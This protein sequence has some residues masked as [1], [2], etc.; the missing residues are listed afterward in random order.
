MSSLR[1]LR[2][3]EEAGFLLEVALGYSNGRVRCCCRSERAATRPPRSLRQ[4]PSAR[5]CS[6]PG[7]ARRRRR[8]LPE[9]HTS[10]RGERRNE[11]AAQV[12]RRSRR[13]PGKCTR[14]R[15]VNALDNRQ[16]GRSALRQAVLSRCD[17][18]LNVAGAAPASAHCRGRRL[19]IGPAP[20]AAGGALCSWRI[21]R[22]GQRRPPALLLLCDAHVGTSRRSPTAEPSR[23]HSFQS[24][25]VAMSSMV[26]SMWVSWAPV[27][28]GTW[29]SMIAR[30][31]W[32]SASIAGP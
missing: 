19:S 12:D 1:A 2:D 9:R 26:M 30:T 23:T 10:R 5:K 25:G 24:V 8:R 29:R 6:S 15:S 32:T 21:A 4:T 3:T 27:R 17:E 20:T 28:A 18:H 22:P 16:S 14:S 31:A 7:Y 13:T 11:R